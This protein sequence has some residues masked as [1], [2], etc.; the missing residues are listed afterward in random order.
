MDRFRETL[1]AAREGRSLRTGPKI[2]RPGLAKLTKD[3]GWP[4]E[5]HSQTIKNIEDGV[6]AD[7]GVVTI[8]RILDALEITLSDFFA[9][10][11][12]AMPRR[13]ARSR[14]AP[15]E[16]V[17]TL[18]REAADFLALPPT[19]RREVLAF[20]GSQERTGTA[21]SGESTPETTGSA[22][23]KSARG[24]RRSLRA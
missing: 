16:D 15:V 5:I 24:R 22:S 17:Q 14:V 12:G 2:G 6:T 8:A 4:K 23:S 21:R 7:P 19:L 13:K 10:V 11:D 3:D 18:M 1:K 20:S 9:H